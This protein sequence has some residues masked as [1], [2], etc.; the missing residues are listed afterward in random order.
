MADARPA[1]RPVDFDPFAPA[2]VRPVDLALTEPQSE[3][4][5]AAAVSPEA[6]CSYNQCFAFAFRGPL[7]VESLRAALD[8][9]VARHDGLRV[10][11][12]PDGSGQTVRP[13]FPVAIPLL[14][15][16][17]LDPEARRGEIDRLLQ[18]ECDTPFDLTLGPLLRAFV[19]REFETR[20][21]FVLT[22]HHIVCDGWSSSVLFADLGR[23]YVADVTGIPARLSPPASYA[24][25]VAAQATPQALAAAAE[26]EAYWAAQYTTGAPRLDLPLPAARPAV[27]T[28]KA[29]KVELRIGS[30][31]YGAVKK[32]GARAGATLFTTL[33]AGF[34]ILLCRL[35]GQSDFVVG[36][37]FAGQFALEN[38]HLVAHCVNTIPLRAELDPEAS[39]AVNLR[40]VRQRFGEAQ[41][42]AR[43]TFGSLLRRL[44]LPRD[45][46]RTP[47]VDVIFN[48]D[49]V[50]APFDFGDVAIESVANPRS[51]FNFE[52][53]MNVVDSGSDM[54]VEC[55]YNAD[56]FD[57]PTIKRWLSHYEVILAEAVRQPDTSVNAVVLL[58]PAEADEIRSWNATD[59]AYPQAAPA[60]RLFE[61][62]V[63]RTPDAVA[64]RFEGRALTYRELNRRANRLAGRL[65]AAGV[66][67]D[68]L[69]GL[70]A[71]RSFEM[72]VAVLAILKAGGAY[73][74]LD[75]SLPAERIRGMIE[76]TRTPVLVAQR[77]MA[78]A[79][80]EHKAQVVEIEAN[81]S[82]DATDDANPRS[83]VALDHLAYVI[84]TSGS[85]GRPKGALNTH[86]GLSNQLLWRQEEYGLDASDRVL[87][88]TSYGFDVSVWEFFWP[89]M[90]GATLV[91]ARPEGHKDPRYLAEIIQSEGI[92]TLHFVPSMLQAMMDEPATAECTSLRRLFS[93]GEALSHELQERVFQILPGTELFNLYGPAETAI[94]V[95]HWKC[96]RNDG[97]VSV[98]IG[99]P[100]ANTQIHLLDPLG[101]PVAVGLPG[102]LYIG[103][104]QVG[105]GYC[106]RPELTAERFLPDLS[107]SEPDARLY[108]TGDLAR[109][110]PGGIIEYLGRTDFQV[111]IR[112]QRIELGEIEAV[113]DE[114]PEVRQA[115]VH[116]WTVSADDVRIVACC[117]PAKAGSLASVKL[118][119]HL[120]ER[121]PA[122][123][124]PQHF[125]L[126]N[127]MPLT[128]NGK[129]DRR[130]LPTPAAEENT[131][132][133]FEAPVG[134][135]ESAIAGIWTELIQPARPIARTDRFFEM[136]GH[137]LLAMQ[138][139]R[140]ME[141]RLSVRLD[142][143]VL[144]R[145]SLAEIA[146]QV[147]ARS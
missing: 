140:K 54:V 52:L 109:Y 123:M 56:L 19:V 42:H 82:V 33:L 66:G 24:D 23:F 1:L 102:E 77:G 63:A 8:Q 15:V 99:R 146:A 62:Q 14:D 48:I 29:G 119:K 61:E 144:L 60:H 53:G 106:G 68:V 97:R 59:R 27:K 122:Y 135:V 5:T 47:L 121:L 96:E 83:P 112:G 100:V 124:I 34:E 2:S 134:P 21:H 88:K 92:T 95:T 129:V 16:S 40:R 136:G 37:P 13:P 131:I 145:D 51:H 65:T 74:P 147:Q 111:K 98:P 127:E 93:G 108:R 79:L 91:V 44:R 17:A 10:A 9:V 128:P 39:F 101:N 46:S 118:R 139:L 32:A 12:T 31:L 25:Y 75:A 126:M 76:D 3:M 67:P 143:Q 125:L 133:R 94:D 38:P 90:T 41:D 80:P 20:H 73:V 142:I 130:R 70:V 6:N 110:R 85:T 4:W 69:V 132:G 72:V 18:R 89:L 114:H 87:H 78:E 58:T 120:R 7:R 137:S 55:T 115:A 57:G 138:F 107:R 103:G 105:R 50:G 117:V 43:L 28:Y 84:F 86:R 36:I 81:P 30:E 64:L 71:E 11:I 22:V 113:L 26:D 49:K 141:Q 45:H 104:A 116:L 35:S